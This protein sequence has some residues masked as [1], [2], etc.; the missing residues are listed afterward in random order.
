M[1]YA[2][3]TLTDKRSELESAIGH[4]DEL[5][6]SA[7]D[8]PTERKRLVRDLKEINEALPFLLENAAKEK[9]A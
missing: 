8:N 6:S 5:K 3:K 2:I 1:I 4:Q 7:N 9:K